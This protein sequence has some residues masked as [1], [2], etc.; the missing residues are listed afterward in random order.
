MADVGLQ[1]VQMENTV[2]GV[3]VSAPDV[4]MTGCVTV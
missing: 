2:P 4:G 1:V 3:A